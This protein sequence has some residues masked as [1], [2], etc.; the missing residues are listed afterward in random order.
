[1]PATN[2]TATCTLVEETTPRFWVITEVTGELIW[3]GR[4]R[5]DGF[6][7]VYAHIDDFVEFIEK[8]GGRPGFS[9]N[10]DPELDPRADAEGRWICNL[11][12][13]DFIAARRRAAGESQ[14]VGVWFDDEAQ[15]SPAVARWF[16]DFT[17]ALPFFEEQLTVERHNEMIKE[18]V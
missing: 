1:M 16:A 12:W 15:P 8:R 6:P 9:F 2:A 4:Q 10:R 7:A 5:E 11:V 14:N 17:D 3:V 18:F 13:E